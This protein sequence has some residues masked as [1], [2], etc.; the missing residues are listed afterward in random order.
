MVM[1][2]TSGIGGAMATNSFGSWLSIFIIVATCAIVLSLFVVV[3]SGIKGYKITRKWVLW[4][5]NSVRYFF[6]GIG[7]LLTLAVPGLI[8]YYF[9]KQAAQGNVAPIKITLY[10][11]VGYFVIAFIGFLASKVI[12]RFKKLEKKAN[13]NE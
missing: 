8:I 7:A 9:G 3:L 2:M 6:F 4:L 13:K 11:I 12:K 10:I 5:I 1:N